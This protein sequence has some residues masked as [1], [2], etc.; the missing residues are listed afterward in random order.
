MR[1]QV[2]IMEQTPVICPHDETI[3]RDARNDR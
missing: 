1:S 2:R 3:A